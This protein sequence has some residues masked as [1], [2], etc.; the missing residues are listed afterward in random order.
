LFIRKSSSGG[1]TLASGVGVWNARSG[2]DAVR[3]SLDR[4]SLGRSLK[5]SLYYFGVKHCGI[6]RLAQIFSN[7][8]IM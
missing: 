7:M 5:V 8:A 2:P 3:Y 4:L 1:A 6:G